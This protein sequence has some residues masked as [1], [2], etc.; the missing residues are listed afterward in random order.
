MRSLLY[1]S[2]ITVSGYFLNGY[3]SELDAQDA[4]VIANKAEKSE[5]V[6]ALYDFKCEEEKAKP[7]VDKDT[8]CALYDFACE[9]AKAAAKKESSKPAE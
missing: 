9:D 7:K 1:I 6:C 5:K 4:N 8:P 2:I 3:S